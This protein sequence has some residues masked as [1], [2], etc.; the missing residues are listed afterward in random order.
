MGIK[1][2]AKK[3]VWYT[4]FSKVLLKAINVFSELRL[5]ISG[6]VFVD[7]VPFSQSVKHRAYGF[8]KT[9]SFFLVCSLSKSFYKGSGSSCVISVSQPSYTALPDPL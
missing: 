2:P 8:I 7:N 1:K 9:F 3:P 4:M 6:F 5:V